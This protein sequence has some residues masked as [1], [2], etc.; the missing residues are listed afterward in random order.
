M[1]ISRLLWTFRLTIYNRRLLRCYDDSM[2]SQH[3]LIVGFRNLP[4]KPQTTHSYCCSGRYLF[5]ATVPSS[6]HSCEP[7]PTAHNEQFRYDSNCDMFDEAR[8]TIRPYSNNVWSNSNE[9]HNRGDI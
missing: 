6:Y 5:H 9:E 4:A 7:E 3:V 1:N 8:F 2:R